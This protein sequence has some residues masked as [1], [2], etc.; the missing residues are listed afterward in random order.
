MKTKKNS[1][2]ILILLGLSAMLSACG[3]MDMLGGSEDLQ[4]LQ[5]GSED[6]FGIGA[7]KMIAGC[8]HFSVADAEGNTIVAG[9]AQFQ[10]VNGV[11][12]PNNLEIKIT[13][14]DDAWQSGAGAT[15]Q[16]HRVELSSGYQY[17]DNKPAKF[18]SNSVLSVGFRGTILNTRINPQT[19][20]RFQAMT[21]VVTLPDTPTTPAYSRFL[22]PTFE[23]DPA[24]YKA[25]Y[26]STLYQWHPFVHWEAPETPLE[27]LEAANAYCF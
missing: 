10:K 26:G 4:S 27:Y 7:D 6:P 1:F 20:R 15:L 17:Q 9:N 5:Q 3:G 14:I 21:V 24:I 18:F 19:G 22:I 11:N 16:F 13:E 23:A 8:N 2:L 12:D 25:K